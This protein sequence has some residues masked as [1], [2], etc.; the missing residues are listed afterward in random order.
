MDGGLLDLTSPA[1]LAAIGLAI[2]PRRMTVNLLPADLPKEGAYFDLSIALGLLGAMGVVDA[3]NLSAYVVL[4]K[5][6]LDGRLTPTPGM[7]LVALHASER[8]L[9]LICPAAQGA[10]A[11]S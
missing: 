7:L 4:G 9:G 1:A 2:P 11:A 3:E 10:E 6:G 8:S 5:L